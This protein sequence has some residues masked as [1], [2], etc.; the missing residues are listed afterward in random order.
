MLRKSMLFAAGAILPL[1]AA[2]AQPLSTVPLIP[3]E[4]LFGNPVKAAGRISP[5]G[6]WLSWTA[7]RN[8]VMNLWVAPTADPTKAR[9]LTD[10]RN[11]PIRSYFWSPDS[12]QLL[13]VND[14]GGDENFLLYGVNVV[15]G[16]QRAL[17]PFEKTRV[18]IVGVS[19]LVPGRILVGINN[20]DPKCTTSTASTSPAA[21]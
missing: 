8:N 17:T 1:G 16:A 2:L 3:R 6:K 20:R 11:R 10:E 13:F 19:P 4:A 12:R 5:D 7:P 14:K 21:S 15:T 9:A 18:D